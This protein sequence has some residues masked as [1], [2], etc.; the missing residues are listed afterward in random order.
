MHR[1]LAAAGVLR[2]ALPAL[3]ENATL[4]EGT[5]AGLALAADVARDLI[6]RHRIDGAANAVALER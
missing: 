4:P 3:E 1:P 2:P 6:R 5:P